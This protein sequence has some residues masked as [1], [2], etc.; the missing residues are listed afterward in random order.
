[1]LR[2]QLLLVLEARDLERQELHV[3]DLRKHLGELRLNELVR[4]DG[5][6]RELHAVLRV[7][8]RAV[9][10]GRRRADDAPRDAEARRREAGER[11]LHAA[12][13][14]QDGVLRD[15]HVLE[16]Q[17]ARDAGAQAG[18]LVNELG[19]EALGVGRDEEAA[20]LAVDAADLRPDER[21][22]A[23]LPLVI[24]RLVPLRTQLSP[25]STADGAHARGVRA[26]VRLGQP[27]AADDLAPR[28]L[29]QVASS[30]AP[31]CRSV[32][33]DTSRATPARSRTSGCRSRRARAPA[34][35]GRSRRRSGPR[36]RSPSG[37][38]PAGPAPRSRG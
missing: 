4:R 12:D 2:A 33:R 25:S 19:R 1:M 8:H 31:P 9:E 16:N 27:E 38:S 34:S 23:R 36:S 37:C 17:L 28:H 7:V 14:R 22:L 11:A 24:Q 29:G 30:S 15:A 10:A 35:P 18:L 13:V 26:V 21:E 6:A 3:R 32:D 20:D 5:L